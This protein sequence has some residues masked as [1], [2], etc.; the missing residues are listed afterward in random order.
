[1]D[2]HPFTLAAFAIDPH[3]RRKPDDATLLQLIARGLSRVAFT[4]G[5]ALARFRRP[6]APRS[7]G[8]EDRCGTR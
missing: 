2:R 8:R 6:V 3:G 5:L 4:S 7:G 1:M